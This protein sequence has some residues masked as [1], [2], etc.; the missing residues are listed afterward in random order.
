MDIEN[1][2]RSQVKIQKTAGV[3]Q[4]FPGW[5]SNLDGRS[6]HDGA[7]ARRPRYQAR[8]TAV[9]VGMEVVARC[10]Y[11]LSWLWHTKD[12]K[13][14][15]K[16]SGKDPLQETARARH[17]AF[18]ASSFLQI[19]KSQCRPERPGRSGCGGAIRQSKGPESHADRNAHNRP[20]PGIKFYI[21]V[22]DRFVPF[23]AKLR[24]LHGYGLP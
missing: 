4:C 16:L 18:G 19:S 8:A 7:T 2:K 13:L 9:L 21:H 24:G 10:L 5:V 12:G 14:M 15:V 22:S 20:E 6:T 1:T 11:W 17:D 3:E 23:W